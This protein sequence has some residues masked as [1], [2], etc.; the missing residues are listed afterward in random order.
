MGEIKIQE[1]ITCPTCGRGFPS[2]AW[3]KVSPKPWRL[4][5]KQSPNLRWRVLGELR[6][7]DELVDHGAFEAVRSRLLEAVANWVFR[8]WLDIRDVLSRVADLKRW[9]G[10]WVWHQQV[11]IR[12]VLHRVDHSFGWGVAPAEEL[13]LVGHDYKIGRG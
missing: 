1:T 11:D 4:G 8:G 6:S 5:V 12:P 3:A 10:R 13:P 9:G 7:P 2:K